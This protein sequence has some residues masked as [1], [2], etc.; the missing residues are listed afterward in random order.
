MKLVQ[1]LTVALLSM[2]VLSTAS[3]DMISD[4]IIKNPNV[5]LGGNK[6]PSFVFFTHDLTDNLV[7]PFV[8]GLDTIT[9]ATLTIELMDNGDEETFRFVAGPTGFTQ[10]FSGANTPNAPTDYVNTLTTT[11]AKLSETGKLDVTVFV[12]G[13][14]FTFM[15]SLLEAQVL[16]GETESTDVPEPFSLALMGLGLAGISVVRRRK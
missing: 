16:R 4:E 7:N 9:S 3:A 10:V 13:G 6:N 12:D 1:Q 8:A 11:I 14:A 2:F 5:K 15:S